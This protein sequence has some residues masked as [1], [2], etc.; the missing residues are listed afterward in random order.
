MSTKKQRKLDKKRKAKRQ[1]NLRS[2]KKETLAYSG[3]K[4]KTE[5]LTPLIFETERAIHEAFMISRR[6]FTDHDVRRAL[7]TMIRRLRQNRLS[8]GEETNSETEC[9]RTAGNAEELIVWSILFHWKQSFETQPRP[10]RDKT[11]GVLR[12]I[13]GSIDVWGS[14]DPKSRGYLDYIE[15]FLG[16]L[17]ANLREISGEE[18]REL[19]VPDSVFDDTDGDP[20]TPN[21]IVDGEVHDCEVRVDQGRAKSWRGLFGW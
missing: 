1:R 2:K 9:D 18:L 5:E 11:V 13:L 3:M 14:I 17:G 16:Q 8:L 20:S 12:T 10:S 6:D 19:G 21:E 15:D 7:E 4:Y